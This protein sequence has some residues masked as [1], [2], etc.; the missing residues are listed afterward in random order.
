MSHEESHG[1]AEGIIAAAQSSRNSG[2]SAGDSLEDGE[3]D[4]L[5]PLLPV[6]RTSEQ[7]EEGQTIYTLVRAALSPFTGADDSRMA[8]GLGWS[9]L[10]VIGALLGCIL[11]S[12]AGLPSPLY[13]WLSNS[14]GY[15]YFVSWSVSFYPQLINNYRRKTTVGL[16]VDFAGTSTEN[17]CRRQWLPRLAHTQLLGLGM[18]SFECHWIRL[19]HNV[20]LRPLL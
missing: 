5:A 9:L 10:V 17:D 4:H 6:E 13:R 16:S 14:I 19:L 1:E 11:P 3:S 12:D 2:A 20:R 7:D 15:T 8:I 18:Y